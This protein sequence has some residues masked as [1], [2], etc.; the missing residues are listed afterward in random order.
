MTTEPSLPRAASVFPMLVG[1]WRSGTTLLRSVFD[2]HPAVAVP[3]ETNLLPPVLDRLSHRPFELSAYC[4][5]LRAT[6]R[7]QYWAIPDDEFERALALDPPATLADAVRLTYR[8]YAGHHGKERYADKTPGHLV[9]MDRIASLLPETRF[10]HLIR[11]GRDVALAL[12]DASF[13][14]RSIDEAALHWRSRVSTGRAM[15]AAL[16]P[17]RYFEVRYEDLVDDPAET[18]RQ[19]CEFVDL[20]FDD[21]MLRHERSANALVAR[22]TNPGAHRELAKPIRSGVRDWRHQMTSSEVARFELIAGATL[23]E[24]GYER[25]ATITFPQRVDAAARRA[26]LGAIRTYRRVRRLNSATW[27]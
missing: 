11:D 6:P 26:R 21:E 22:T 7:H 1:C 5:V 4:E 17:A 14:P 10:V 9:H 13:G 24:L 19:V 18:L 2:S 25:A 20:A 16:G 8:A 12:R 3:D 23:D 27:W 15:G